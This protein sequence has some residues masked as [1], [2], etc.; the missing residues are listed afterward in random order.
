M[1][2]N[3]RY[4]GAVVQAVGDGELQEFLHFRHTFAGLDRTYADVQALEGFE[5]HF[6]AHVLG[7]IVGCF[8]GLFRVEEFLDLR[9]D[10]LVFDFLKEECGRAQLVAGG[11][12][13][14]AAEVVP[15]EGVHGQHFAQAGTGEGEEGFEGDAQV[16]G[17]LEG[18]VDDCLDALGVC[19]DDLPGFAVG[20]IF[21]ADT[22]QVHGLLQ[23]IAEAE[24][25][26]QFLH[27]GLHVLEL[28]QRLLVEV[29]QRT[30]GGHH[31]VVV[32]LR[33]LQ[34]AVDEVAI[35]GHEFVVV[36]RLKVLPGE[37]IV[38]RFGRIGREDVAQHILLAR[39]IHEVFVEPYGPVA[40][41][42]Y[43]IVFKVEKL[44]GGHVVG[45]DVR[46][47]CLEHGW[48]DDAVE[49]DVVLA[50]KVNQARVLLL[51]PLLPGAPALG[52]AVAEF[53]GVGDIADGRVEPYVEHLALGPFHGHGNAPVEVARHGAGLQVHVEPRLALAV[54]VGSPLLVLLEYPLAQPLLVFSQGQVPVF[55]GTLYEAVALVVLVRRVDEFVGREGGAALFALVAIGI[56]GTAAGAC[57]HDVAVGEEFARHLVAVLFL[58]VLLEDAFVVECAEE[59]GGKLMV[60]F[61]GCAAVDVERDAEFF[62][63]VLDKLVIAVH[64][65]LRGDA[66][67][68]G[69][70]GHGHTVLVATADEAHIALFEAEIA[71]VDVG[72]YVHTCQV[73]D[74][75][76]A[77][78]IGQG[79]CHQRAF[80][81]LFHGM[82]MF[83]LI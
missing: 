38:A 67:L 40:R 68:A 83:F 76:T 79:G 7:A 46:A 72:R 62:E 14:G 42:R 69:A 78:G 37:I 52:V 35:D 31:A 25:L 53:F 61:G 59:V 9:F 74:V 19:L 36:A 66:L 81:L 43:F 51:P 49:H 64:D 41:G 56:V 5:V 4:D 26:E 44:V 63:R 47:V 75:H 30:A 60:D 77:V 17:Q 2:G 57:A 82:G 34:G 71:H 73:A 70:D 27:F 8:V 80:E 22:C 24:C 10:D 23:R 58:G 45:Q 48:E 16:G 28:A 55:R 12:E 20:Q 18:D 15:F 33:Q 65:G 39:H 3:A 50:D 13:V 6:G 29:R 11:E 21:V 32:F 54:D 1:L